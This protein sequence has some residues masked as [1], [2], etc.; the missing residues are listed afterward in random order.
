[1]IIRRSTPVVHRHVVFALVA[2]TEFTFVMQFS[3]VGVSLQQLLDDLAAP[4]RWGGWVLTMF[5]IGR[6]V[7]MAVVGRLSER[8]GATVVYALGFA[9]FAASSALCAAA[10]N[11][12]VLIIGRALQGLASGGLGAAGMTIV[13]DSYGTQRARAIGYLSSVLPFGAVLGPTVGGLIV[14]HFGWRWTFGF[15]VPVGFAACVLSIALLPRGARRAGQAMD[16]P[17]IGLIALAVT[18]LVY[19]LTELARKDGA[20]DPTVV[21]GTIALALVAGVLLVRQERRVRVPVLPLDLLRQPGL[22]AANAIAFFFGVCWQGVFSLLPYYVQSA[23]GL[24]ASQAGGIMAPRALVMVLMSAAASFLLPR[25]GYRWPLLIGLVGQSLVLLAFSRGLHEPVI[26]GQLVH[27]VAWLT[28]VSLGAGLA[29]G[30][31]NP[32]MNNA[33]I[34]LAPDRI[35]A[36]AG[37][38]GMFM[39]LGGTVGIAVVVLFGAQGATI[40]GGIETAFLV[41]SAVMLLTTLLIPRVP[42][43]ARAHAPRPLAEPR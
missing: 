12:Y 4:L 6:V 37:M 13:G 8:L 2:I 32:A 40:A 23:Y 25:T 16:L 41:F 29:F 33:A 18:A 30:A 26:A 9:A 36:I 34:D 43:Q 39:T 22:I 17:G 28:A 38:R 21:G 20:A 1:M 31:A 15:N 19:A 3:M 5:M 42:E 35:A 14:D 7:A 11:I 27:S 10:P 24:S